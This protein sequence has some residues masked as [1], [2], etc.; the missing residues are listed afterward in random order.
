MG[1]ENSENEKDKSDGDENIMKSAKVTGPPVG[2]FNEAI[3]AING[4]A[5]VPD[6]YYGIKDWADALNISRETA[7][8]KLR[9]LHQSGRA[10]MM[11]VKSGGGIH[12]YY[13]LNE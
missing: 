4:A 6:G 8:K 12:K 9:M 13:K 10:D 2:L 7:R 1:S 3:E 5:E 11:N